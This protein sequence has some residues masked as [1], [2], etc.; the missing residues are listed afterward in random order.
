MLS[1]DHTRP[2]KTESLNAVW[3]FIFHCEINPLLIIFDCSIQMHI[4][5]IVVIS[6]HFN[7]N[8]QQLLLHSS[9]DFTLHIHKDGG[10]AR[11]G[12]SGSRGESCSLG[13]VV[14]IVCSR[15]GKMTR[16]L[17]SSRSTD[18]STDRKILEKFEEKGESAGSDM[19]SKD[20][21]EGHFN[22]P[23]LC[24]ASLAGLVKSLLCLSTS[25]VCDMH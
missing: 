3:M 16:I 7:G 20:L 17:Y 1:E 19:C 9:R 13:S 12:S 21:S 24:K 6:V 18:T 14:Y 23:F 11:D 25:A 8:M 4:K 22:R 15:G 5:L 10:V 2:L